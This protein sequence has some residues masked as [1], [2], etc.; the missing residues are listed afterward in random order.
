MGGWRT[1]LEFDYILLNYSPFATAIARQKTLW[2]A[3]LPERTLLVNCP[4]GST[5]R[6]FNQPQ[7]LL[8]FCQTGPQVGNERFLVGESDGASRAEPCA[9]AAACEAAA[10]GRRH[11]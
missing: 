2:Q 4:L 8:D 5:R 10:Q 11:P 6:V 7:R 9:G 3:F 1:L